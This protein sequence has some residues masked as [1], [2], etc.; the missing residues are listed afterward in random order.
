MMRLLEGKEPTKTPRSSLGGRR[1]ADREHKEESVSGRR[2]C[3]SVPNA[4]E[5]SSTKMGKKSLIDKV[6]IMDDLD[7]GS[8]SEVAGT[9]N[10]VGTGGEETRGVEGERTSLDNAFKGCYWQ[11][12]KKNKAITGTKGVCLFPLR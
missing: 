4:T 2:K 11:G 6:R 12:R 5:R 3:S 10:I 8:P 9:Q 1:S 7:K